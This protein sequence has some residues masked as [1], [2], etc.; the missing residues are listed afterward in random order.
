MHKKVIRMSELG[1]K[2]INLDFPYDDDEANALADIIGYSILLTERI[3]ELESR[4]DELES[5][6]KRMVT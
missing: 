4:I 3:K 2:K 1:I 6:N 5:V